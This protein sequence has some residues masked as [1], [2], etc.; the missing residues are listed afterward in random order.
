MLR[1]INVRWLSVLGLFLAAAP[2]FAHHSFIAEFDGDKCVDMTGTFT[3]FEWDNPHGYFYLDVKD[4]KS[5]VVSWTFETVSLAWLKRSGTTRQ[6]FEDAVG[7]VVTVR[8]CLAKNGSPRAAAETLKMPD[9]RVLR[10]GTD[11]EQK[12]S[13]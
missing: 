2:A 8:A 13:N 1:A 4:D 12:P 10:V 5:A 11:Y 9:G 7:K 3:K 6:D